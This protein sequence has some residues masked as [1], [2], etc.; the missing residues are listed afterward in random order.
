MTLPENV[1]NIVSSMVNSFD[2]KD[3]TRQ[4]KQD[5]TR[6]R[7][8]HFED[9]VTFVLE[10]SK[11]TL[12]TALRRYFEK[13]RKSEDI[14]MSQQAL[15]KAKMKLRPE[16]FQLLFRKATVEPMVKTLKKTWKNF[17]VYAMD[18]T[19]VA[20][21]D[22]IKK[23][24]LEEY[25]GVGRNAESPTA[26]ASL[27]YD[28]LNDIVIDGEIKP[29]DT[30]ER[31]LALGH[32]DA[33]IELV[34]HENKLVLFDRGYPSF[35]LIK[36]L[37]DKGIKYVMRVKSKFNTNIDDQQEDDGFVYLRQ[38]EVQIKTRIVKVPLDSDEVETLMTNIYDE[39]LTPDDFKELYFLRWGLE[40]AYYFTKIKLELANFSSLK[41]NGIEIE[42]FATLFMA[43]LVSSIEYEANKNIK[44]ERVGKENKYEYKANQNEIIGILKDRFILAIAC[45]SDNE[46]KKAMDGILETAQRYVVPIRPNR[47]IP[48]NPNPRKVRFH[49]NQKSN[50]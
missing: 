36:Q 2:F 3:Y 44:Q 21:P 13:I 45:E 38:N 43:N 11:N 48:R 27:L 46:R 32:I 41:R 47:S 29:L 30:D 20:L 33:L 25:G 7:S 35:E 34:D 15:S 31:T 22:D 19:K 9:L 37:E 8:M 24:L 26:Q 12:S 14:K 50:A 23:L 4:R 28:V 42:F 1:I 17:Y 5:F 40:T 49:H 39:E 16:G 6:K 18:G 10:A